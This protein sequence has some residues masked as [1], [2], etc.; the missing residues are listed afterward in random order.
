MTTKEANSKVVKLFNEWERDFHGKT[1]DQK[2]EGEF[3]KK[4][5]KFTQKCNDLH[6]VV[7]LYEA[8][9]DKNALK[10]ASI[11]SSLRFVE[12]YRMLMKLQVKQIK[13]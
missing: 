5:E 13:G 4:R 8:I 3:Y 12:P 9:S 10:M 1:P 6:K 11:C 7:G 2:Q